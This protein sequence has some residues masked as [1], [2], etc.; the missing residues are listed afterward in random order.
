MVVNK[1]RYIS[2]VLAGEVQLRKLVRAEQRRCSSTRLILVGYSQ[3]AEVTG[4]AYLAAL[5]NKSLFK[6]VV[7][8]VLFGDPLYNHSDASAIQTALQR[9]TQAALARNGVLTDFGPLYVGAPHSFPRSTVGRVVSYC[10]SNDP[11]CQGAIGNL[12][13]YGDHWLYT[14]LGEPEDAAEYFARRAGAGP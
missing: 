8:V 14:D 9:R 4:D 13:A 5:G 2:S 10:I 7:G 1:E 3:G 6:S 12:I 11:I